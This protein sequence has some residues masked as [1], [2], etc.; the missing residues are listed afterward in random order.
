[1]VSLL[2]TVLCLAV[3]PL[4][5]AYPKAE[6]VEARCGNIPS[7]YQPPSITTLPDPF[8]FINGDRV[9]SKRDFRCRQKE[10]AALF[11]RFE[12]GDK[13]A[14]DS[15]KGS[16]ANNI[17][18][19]TVTNNKKS[20]AFNATI[21]Y[22]E[23]GKAPYPA[24]ITLGYPNIPKLDGVAFINFPNDQIAGQIG[25]SYRGQGL[26]YELYGKNASA[27]SLT[28]WAWGVSRLIDALEETRGT[29]INVEFIGVTGCSRNGKGAFVVGALDDRIGLT[30]PQESGTGGSGCW[31]VA[32]ATKAAGTNIQTAAQIITENTWLSQRFDPWT[33]KVSSLPIDH[34]LLA[35]LVAPRGLLVIDNDID[36]LGPTST[37]V[38]MGVGQLVYKALGETDAFGYSDVGAHNH[39]LFPDSQKPQLEAFVKKWLFDKEVD[40]D[41]VFVTS[42]NITLTDWY[43]WK[44]PRL[45]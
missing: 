4:A 10:I 40:T 27:G 13:P 28:A 17:L 26:F 20:I 36:W 19:V 44:V 23:K 32:D 34:H 41:G 2:A 45:Y 30:I 39:C 31:R 6:A 12:L 35:G 43:K 14:A 7:N 3:A 18:T 1:M 22:P 38:C 8:T 42:R 33:T 25:A 24:I 5:T 37:A 9:K 16:F 15:V 29:K 11:A 21:T